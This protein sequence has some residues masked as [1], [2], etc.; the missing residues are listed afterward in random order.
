MIK[1]AIKQT[2]KLL[3]FKR[4]YIVPYKCHPQQNKRDKEQEFA[5]CIIQA[6]NTAQ[7]H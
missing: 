3:I 5:E 4:Q 2:V 7:K 1:R 6:P